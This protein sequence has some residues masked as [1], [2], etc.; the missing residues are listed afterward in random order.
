[1]PAASRFNVRTGPGT[2]VPELTD[3]EFGGLIASDQPSAV[4]KALYWNAIGQTWA[5][6]TDATAT[7]LP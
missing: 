4:E 1:M 3:E 2:P 5:A 6:G 7:R